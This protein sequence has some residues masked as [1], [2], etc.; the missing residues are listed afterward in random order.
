MHCSSTNFEARDW[1]FLIIDYALHGMLSDNLK[2][3]ASI[4]RRSPHFY[5]DAVVKTM[6]CLSY[7][8]VLLRCL[9]SLKAREVLKEAHNDIR[10][11]HQSG[12]KLNDRLHRLGY[13]WPAMIADAVE[14]TRCKACQIH[15]N[16]IYQPPKLL[17]PTVISWP[18]KAW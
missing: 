5:Y 13:Y 18:L 17:Y 16:F 15:V 12:L 9:S 2:E 1:R 10:G 8:G 14:Y 4:R 6:Y 7:D 11:A 3:A